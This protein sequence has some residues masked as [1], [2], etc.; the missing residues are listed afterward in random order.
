MSLKAFHIAFITVSTL[1]TFGM[2]VYAFLEVD[3]AMRFVWTLA[4]LL[5][6]ILLIVYGMRFLKKMKH[7]G[8][9]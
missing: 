1:L 6:G 5:A 9:T 3:G 2:G 7:L 8:S 4:A